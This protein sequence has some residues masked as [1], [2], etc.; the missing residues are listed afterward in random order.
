M[1]SGHIGI[2]EKPFHSREETLNPCK[3]M[4]I[5]VEHFSALKHMQIPE[6]DFIW[7]EAFWTPPTPPK[8]DNR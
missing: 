7:I 5:R 1:R 8:I 4:R 3:A 2:L 6:A